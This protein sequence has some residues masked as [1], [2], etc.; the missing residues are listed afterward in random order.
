MAAGPGI[1]E[2]L[3]D[4]GKDVEAELQRLITYMNDEVVPQVRR[5]SSAALRA[6]AGQLGRLAES[7]ERGTVRSTGTTGGASQDAPGGRP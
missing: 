4:A 6:V 1:N 3:R 7:L 2:R 5:G